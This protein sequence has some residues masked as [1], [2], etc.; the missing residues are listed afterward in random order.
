D[1]RLHS[2]LD[3][4]EAY[5]QLGL[6]ADSPTPAAVAAYLELRGAA[7]AAGL[8]AP[9]RTWLDLLDRSYRRVLADSL[10]HCVHACM[11]RRDGL[12]IS[13]SDLAR[14]LGVDEKAILKALREFR[15]ID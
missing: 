1:P 13:L 3:L 4:G 2:H 10:V 14:Q 6:A 15:P 9:V 12:P 5:R 7:V 8:T 11:L